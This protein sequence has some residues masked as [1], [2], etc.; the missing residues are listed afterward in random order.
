MRLIL[1]ICCLACLSP[2]PVSA[3]P[4]PLC[5]EIGRTPSM[6][7]AVAISKTAHD[8]LGYPI[9]AESLKIPETTISRTGRRIT[10]HREV[11]DLHVVT[12]YLGD[13]LSEGLSAFQDARRHFADAKV[14]F[15]WGWDDE[16]K[17]DCTVY[18]FQEGMY[19]ISE[20]IILGSYK[21]YQ[22]ALARAEEIS[23]LSGVAFSDMGMIFDP[24]KGLIFPVDEGSGGGVRRYFSR[25]SNDLVP[26]TWDCITIELS[27]AYTG[28]EKGYYII[29]GGI[30]PDAEDKLKLFEK[31]VPDAYARET[32]LYM[33]C[34]H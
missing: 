20:I 11:R 24:E 32:I 33:G 3:L 15:S 4:F 18:R 21:E 23:R 34:R 27:D 26:G 28:F 16:W 7:E 8:L 17:A 31:A 6:D 29:V 25:R 19:V 10:V 1:T 22:T 9:D 2:D 14:V 5:V 13:S 30:Y 12:C